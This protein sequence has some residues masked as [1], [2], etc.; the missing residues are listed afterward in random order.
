MCDLEN[1]SYCRR[2][3]HPRAVR[4]LHFVVTLGVVVCMFVWLLSFLTLRDSGNLASYL[5][6]QKYDCTE[7]PVRF[8][9]TC[10]DCYDP[11]T[12][13]YDLL[14]SP[15]CSRASFPLLPRNVTLSTVVGCGPMCG[16]PPACSNRGS[17]FSPYVIIFASALLC[18]G[19]NARAL[20]EASACPSPCAR[21]GP[22][23]CLAFVCLRAHACVCRS[24]Y[25]CG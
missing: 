25:V 15:S 17:D 18:G 19:E 16:A 24:L 10:G 9:A 20:S 23:V 22:C 12:C 1:A 8:A 14:L 4:M 3:R 13:E 21:V 5:A 2:C 11:T 6:N 7:T